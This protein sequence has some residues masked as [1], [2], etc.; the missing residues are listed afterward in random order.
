MKRVKNKS[1]G[2]FKMKTNLKNIT[3]LLL[4]L[5]MMF[6]LV[7]PIISSAKET[8][9]MWAFPLTEDDLEILFKPIVEPFEAQNPDIDVNIEIIPWQNRVERMVTAIAAGKAPDV[10]YLNTDNFVAFVA[11]DALLPVEKYMS[12][13][14]LADLKIG[15][16]QGFTWKGHLYAFPILMVYMTEVYNKE[17]FKKAGL[18]PPTTW[19]EYEDCATKLTIDKNGNH[20]AQ[21]GFDR[22]NVMQWGVAD[23]AM[24]TITTCFSDVWLFQAGGDYFDE[25]GKCIFNSPEGIEAATM[26][27]KMFD[28]WIDPAAKGMEPEEARGLIIKEKAAMMA[29][30]QPHFYKMALEQNP[31]LPIAV[32]PTMKHRKKV[33]TGSVAA[34]GIFSSSKHP[35]LAAKWLNWLTNTQNMAHFCS[36]SWF[37]PPRLSA[38]PIVQEN[39]RSEFPSFAE[40]VE[41]DKYMKVVP[42]EQLQT[43]WELS[44]AEF[45]SC[46]LHKKTPKQAMDDLTQAVNQFLGF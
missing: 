11:K 22:G 45:Q 46:I 30:W 25:N 4:V 19:D 18:T 8:V 14:T 16:K 31:N 40:I 24:G 9:S 28:N 17:M 10:A 27:V 20:S 35:D 6:L 15:A 12:D 3:M 29:N 39:L 44:A 23:G 37:S 21:V 13:E 7:V 34:Y 33:G 38:N 2:K 41:Q 43:I 5:L 42:H 36:T 1:G 26:I 32:G